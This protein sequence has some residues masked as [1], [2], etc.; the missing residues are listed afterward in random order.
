MPC[1]PRRPS[2]PTS[3]RTSTPITSS[4]SKT[5]NLPCARTSRIFT[6]RA[7]SPPQHVTYDKG[8]GRIEE[9]A[10]WTSTEL[11]G[12]AEFPHA[13]QVCRVEHKV[14]SLDGTPRTPEVLYS[15]TSLTPAE[16]DPARL[17]ELHRGH[18]SIEN[19]LHY[20]RD[21]TYDEDRSQVRK[22]GAP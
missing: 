18:W 4:R 1:S 20:V 17:L 16:A 22:H 14:H 11:V 13:Q 3:S 6:W 12:Y 8:H 10:I 9:R 5:I 19:K 7:H 21:R 15:I 2:L